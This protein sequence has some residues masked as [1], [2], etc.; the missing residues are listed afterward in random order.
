MIIKITKITGILACGLIIIATLIAY[1]ETKSPVSAAQL[2]AF[3][4]KWATCES[5]KAPMNPEDEPLLLAASEKDPSGPWAAYISIKFTQMKFSVHRLDIPG[6]ATLY[7]RTSLNY[8]KP[9]RDILE[10]SAKARPDDEG[11]QLSLYKIKKHWRC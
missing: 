7:H 4:K 10:K 3:M 11:L 6:C 1:G 2:D 8:L 9:A 5:F